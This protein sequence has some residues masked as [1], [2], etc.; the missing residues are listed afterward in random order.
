MKINNCPAC[1][2]T[3][4]DPAKISP[5]HTT[6]VCYDCGRVFE[7]KTTGTIAA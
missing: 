5:E 4:I 7:V 3:N 1:G 2:G 6:A